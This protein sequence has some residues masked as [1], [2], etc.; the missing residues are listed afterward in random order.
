MA[1]R[2]YCRPEEPT[3]RAAA[4]SSSA[5]RRPPSATPPPPDPPPAVVPRGAVWIEADEPRQPARAAIHLVHDLFVVDPL[6]E[7]AREID[8]RRRAALPDLIEKAG[9]DELQALLDQLVVDLALL[10]DLFRRLE[11]G[12]EAGLELAEA[13]VVQ[14]RGVHVVGGEPAARPPAE[15]DRPGDRPV[16]M[17]R[18]VDGNE[19]LAVQRRLPR[20]GRAG[21][22]QR[23]SSSLLRVAASMS[24]ALGRVKFSSERSASP[25]RRTRRSRPPG[26]RHKIGR[27]H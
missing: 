25:P 1:S 24:A 3:S 8:A 26:T 6:E 5:P 18:I 20:R 22:R 10:L 9:G 7:L 11:P 16:R 4:P 2:S 23:F 14:P 15:L 12:R 21:A 19:D 27:A 17:R 13:N